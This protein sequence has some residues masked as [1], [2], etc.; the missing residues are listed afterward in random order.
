MRERGAIC[1][2]FLKVYQFLAATVEQFH[3]ALEAFG[4]PVHIYNRRFGEHIHDGCHRCGRDSNPPYP[5]GYNGF[6]GRCVTRP[7]KRDRDPCC[8]RRMSL[9]PRWRPGPCAPLRQRPADDSLP[10]RLSGASPN[11]PTLP[12]RGSPS[13]S[14]PVQALTYPQETNCALRSNFD[15]SSRPHALEAQGGRF[16]NVTHWG[17]RPPS[18]AVSD[19][20]NPGSGLRQI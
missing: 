6:R 3:L 14:S 5:Q 9:T 15:S 4:H 12:S 8:C 17:F 10:H 7:I 13:K 1:C 16:R 11:M 20:I 18:L 19:I 2:S